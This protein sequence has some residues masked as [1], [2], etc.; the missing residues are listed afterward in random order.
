VKRIP[1]TYRHFALS[2]L[3]IASSA[4]SGAGGSFDANEIVLCPG[5]SVL[6]E[7]GAD[8]IKVTSV[9]PLERKV[10]VPSLRKTIHLNPRLE[11]W[12]GSFGLFN[13]SA[14]DSATHIVAEEGFQ[15]FKSLSELQNWAQDRRSRMHLVYSSTGLAVAWNSGNRPKTS[16]EGP[17]SALQLEVWQLFIGGSIPTHLPGAEDASFKE[18]VRAP[19]ACSH[20]KKFDAMAASVVAGRLYSGRALDAMKA[21]GVSPEQVER[22]IREGDRGD[23]GER[24]TFSDYSSKSGETALHLVVLNRQGEVIQVE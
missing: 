2:F 6:V 7:S 16:S 8:R 22:L 15:D 4:C 24:I 1:L 21:L 9:A 12:N 20:P 11:R 19:K 14:G 3:V 23:V 18:I 13:A 5:S 10:E 17:A